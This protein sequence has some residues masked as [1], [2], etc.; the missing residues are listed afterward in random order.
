MYTGIQRGANE[1]DM[2]QEVLK[3]MIEGTKEAL[4]PFV[5]ESIWTTGI[6]DIVMRGGRTREGNRL[7]TDQTPIGEK[8]SRALAHVI[9]TQMPGSIE[10][11]KR[12]DRAFEPIDVITKGKFDKYGQ[13][14]EIG[15]ELQ[16]FLGFRAVEIDPVR[17]MKFKIADFRT[18]I[19]N[20]RREFTSP[21]L[22]GGPVCPEE[23]VDRYRV[24]SDALYKVQEKMFND[25]YAART[26]GTPISNLDSEFADRVSK[27]QLDAIKRGEFKPFV[28]SENIEK[29]FADNAR[30]IGD[31]NPYM[32]A[33]SLIKRLI[34]LYDGIPLGARLPETPNP[35]R[36]SSISQLPIL[37]SQ[38][39]QGLSNIPTSAAALPTTTP[40]TGQQTALKGQQVFGTNDTIFGVG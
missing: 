9:K 24:A 13:D 23:I 26:L 11:F 18:G 16:G 1:G 19:N 39:L 27:T 33:R 20:A 7:Y 22:R 36:T 25:Y 10:Q 40:A 28:P 32:R 35:F 21:L 15:N 4:S 31:P 3:S 34:R 14:F 17:A 37:Q 8:F 2:G 30:A 38:A 6:S 12:L 5:S 29:A